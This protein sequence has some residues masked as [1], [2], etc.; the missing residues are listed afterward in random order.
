MVVRT[1]FFILGLCLALGVLSACKRDAEKGKLPDLR[2]VLGSKDNRPFGASVFKKVAEHAFSDAVFSK[3][4]LPFDKW[5]AQNK[6]SE[7]G[8]AHK[9]YVL[10]TPYLSAR[11]KE[12]SAMMDFVREGNVLWICTNGVSD[13]FENEIPTGMN[14]T[15]TE[16]A[17]VRPDLITTHKSLADTSLGDGRPFSYFYFP[18]D[19]IIDTPAN[20]T[21]KPISLNTNG[22]PDGWQMKI[23]DGELILSTNVEALGNYFLL[24]ANNVNY[25]LGLLSYIPYEIEE[26]IY[27]EF[28][29]RNVNR[30]AEGSSALDAIFSNPPLRWAFWIL[31]GLIG[32]AVLTN[33]F[34]KQRIIPLKVANN[35]TTVAFTE[36]I[37][38]LYFNQKDNSNIA[39]KMIQHFLE[40]FRTTYYLP[41]QKLDAEFARV[42][43]GKTEQ[44]FPK[45]ERMVQRMAAIMQ[46]VEVTNEML[47]ELNKDLQDLRKQGAKA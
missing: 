24:T 41:Y 18:L 26:I 8:E 36:T 23:G 17:I 13:A 47:L 9:A 37:S 16:V 21:A 45:T 20:L 33:L 6:T 15:E 43:A 2:V 31:L 7:Y 30:Q 44:P 40:H 3:S 12:V 22:K 29:W 39:Q 32:V 1:K 35:N 25:A 5:Y 42:L 34:R 28:Y 11:P 4:T 27:D 19:G 10:V 38:R 46:G 14:H